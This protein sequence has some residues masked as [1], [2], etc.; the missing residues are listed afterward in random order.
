MQR[1]ERPVWPVQQ[2][3]RAAVML[4]QQV[5]VEI[6]FDQGVSQLGVAPLE[7]FKQII[8]NLQEIADLP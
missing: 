3:G 4:H 7:R 5:P 1:H 8:L 2:A 6:I